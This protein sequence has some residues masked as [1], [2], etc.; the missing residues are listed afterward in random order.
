M[1][2]C[3]CVCVSVFVRTYVCLCVSC[4][5]VYLCEH[6]CVCVC[7]FVCELYVCL[8]RKTFCPRR[9][10]HLPTLIQASTRVIFSKPSASTRCLCIHTHILSHSLAHTSHSLTHTSTSTSTH[11]H[12]YTPR[13][14]HWAATVGPPCRATLPPLGCAQRAS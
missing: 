4:M 11:T 2:P 1:C 3:V 13:R 10:P 7:L 12:T 5:F 6:V 8:I 9:N 14:P